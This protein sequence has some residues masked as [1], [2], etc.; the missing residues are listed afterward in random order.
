MHRQH[1][2]PSITETGFHDKN[3]PTSCVENFLETLRSTCFIDGNLKMFDFSRKSSP[4]K[5]YFSQN[6]LAD[7]A[8]SV[9]RKFSTQ[10]V[11][12]FLAWKPIYWSIR[13]FFVFWQD[14][15]LGR[16]IL[17]PNILGFWE[18]LTLRTRRKVSRQ[19]E[20]MFWVCKL[21]PWVRVTYMILYSNVQGI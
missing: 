11:G 15:P 21:F 13:K 10:L 19:I 8:L 4:K 2:A 6:I 12:V 9:S 20:N 18:V 7:V 16:Q 3:T 17:L 5:L 1:S 14:L